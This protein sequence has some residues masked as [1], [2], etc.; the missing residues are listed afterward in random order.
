V[1]QIKI[2]NLPDLQP[3]YHWDQ[4]EPVRPVF[5]KSNRPPPSALIQVSHK[6]YDKG[7][8][9]VLIIQSNLIVTMKVTTSLKNKIE[10]LFGSKWFNKYTNLHGYKR[11]SVNGPIEFVITEFDC[12]LIVS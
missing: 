12:I 6:Q 9:Q 4:P 2:Q 5:E 1:G 10:Q 7:F 3:V 11:T 8:K